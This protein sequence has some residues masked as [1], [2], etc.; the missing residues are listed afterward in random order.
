MKVILNNNVA[1]LG[2]IGEVV[3]V[4]DGYG[5][6]FLIPRGLAVL[7]NSR[8]QAALDHHIRQMEKRKVLVLSEAK[9]L[10]ALIEKVSVTVSKAVGEEERI[11]GT[12]T[13]A[14]L[15]EL[16]A[17]EDIKVSKRDIHLTEE[18]KKVG[19]YSAEVKL[20][21]EVVAKF[22]LWVVAA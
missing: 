14:E 9:K 8:N 11:F 18:I 2:T 4:K 15:E 17:A 22:K 1:N 20:H 10:A 12:V 16:L 6:N 5:R 21:P 13:T 3:K 7:A 19:V